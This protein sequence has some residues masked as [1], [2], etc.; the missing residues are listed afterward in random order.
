[1]AA[2]GTERVLGKSVV[3]I[4]WVLASRRAQALPL[5]SHLARGSGYP[6]QSPAAKGPLHRGDA[7]FRHA[8]GRHAARD[9]LDQRGVCGRLGGAGAVRSRPG[10][11]HIQQHHLGG[12]C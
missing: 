10:P 3:G 5:E 9:C 12:V 11:L 6:L 7:A 2:I 8:T 1:M 4:S